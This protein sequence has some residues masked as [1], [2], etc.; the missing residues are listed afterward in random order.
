MCTE[1]TNIEYIVFEDEDGNEIEM[2][3]IDEFHYDEKPYIALSAASPSDE[4][5]SE[6]ISFY[7]VIAMDEEEAFDLITDASLLRALSDA[8][9]QRLFDDI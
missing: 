3:I 6:E 1:F 7:E 5:D 4:Q 9:E 8:L 2:E